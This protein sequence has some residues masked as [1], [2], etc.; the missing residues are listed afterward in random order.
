MQQIKT[1]KTAQIG[2]YPKLG[3]SDFIRIFLSLSEF[4]HNYRSCKNACIDGANNPNKKCKYNKERQ[5]ECITTSKTPNATIKNSLICIQI[6]A[7]VHSPFVTSPLLSCHTIII[8]D[9]GSGLSDVFVSG[10]T[11]VPE[12]CHKNKKTKNHSRGHTLTCPSQKISS[13]V[14]AGFHNSKNS[15]KIRHKISQMQR[16]T[17]TGRQNW[18]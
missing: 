14:V 9:L 11:K 2:A 3:W 15:R 6:H 10:Y 5:I 8:H 7:N 16:Y 1:Q 4:I 13:M 17:G 18:Y 12:N